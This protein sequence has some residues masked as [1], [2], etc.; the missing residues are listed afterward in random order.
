MKLVNGTYAPTSIMRV[1]S[2]AEVFSDESACSFSLIGL[3][4]AD[5][6]LLKRL[7]G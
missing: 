5:P 1:K 2:K 7:V 3:N 6:D 4:L